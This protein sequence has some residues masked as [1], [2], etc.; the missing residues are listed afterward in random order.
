MN[1]FFTE[2]LD[3]AL[4]YQVIAHVLTAIIVHAVLLVVTGAIYRI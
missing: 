1:E 4:F 3:I 2:P